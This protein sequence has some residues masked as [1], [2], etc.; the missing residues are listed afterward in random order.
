MTLA[1]SPQTLMLP[2]SVR[3]KHQLLLC[4][5]VT[6]SPLPELVPSHRIQ[7]LN[8]MN[9][10]QMMK[11]LTGL[12]KLPVPMMD[13]YLMPPR[14]QSRPRK[15]RTEKLSGQ[16]VVVWVGITSLLLKPLTLNLISLTIPGREKPQETYAGLSCHATG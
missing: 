7:A 10:F 3:V 12:K 11:I 1:C 8:T 13:I 9:R 16:C 2:L 4:I 6:G 15:C 5:P 14:H